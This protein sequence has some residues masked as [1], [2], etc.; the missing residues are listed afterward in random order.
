MQISN[1]KQRGD[2]LYEGGLTLEAYLRILVFISVLRMFL[3]CAKMQSQLSSCILKSPL[4]MRR[5]YSYTSSSFLER[6][7]AKFSSRFWTPEPSIVISGFRSFFIR[8][9]C[10]L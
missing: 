4:T 1:E 5:M 10:K 8:L 9:L 2:E 7:L 3:R 6:A